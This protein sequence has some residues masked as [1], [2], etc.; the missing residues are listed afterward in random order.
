MV[1]IVTGPDWPT[2]RGLAHDAW[3]G[4]GD[5]AGLVADVVAHG[6]HR[7]EARGT[8]LVDRVALELRWRDQT[9]GEG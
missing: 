2:L 7:V 8:G 1:E 5:V 3:K 4:V 6:Q 9:Q